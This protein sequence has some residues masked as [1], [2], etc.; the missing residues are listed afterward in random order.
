MSWLSLIPPLAV[1]IV[2]IW[3]KKIRLALFLGV[4]LA[5]T[6]ASDFSLIKGLGLALTRIFD[7]AQLASV[8]SL[9]SFFKASNLL[10]MLFVLALGILIEMIRSSRA[11]NAFVHFTESRI[12]DQKAAETSSLILSHI[13]C[14]DDYLSSLTVGSVVR[15]I[16]DRFRIS[17]IKLAFLTDSMAAPITMLTPVSSWAA[18]IIG[19]LNDNGVSNVLTEN[20][21]VLASPYSLYLKILPY[22][23]YSA[24]LIATVWIIVRFRISFGLIERHDHIA[25]TTGNLLG[26]KT[27]DFANH[28]EKSSGSREATVTDFF[29]PIGSL[30]AFTLTFLLYFGGFWLFGGDS[31]FFASMRQ[32]PISLV[33][34]LAGLSSILASSAYYVATHKF[35]I[36]ELLHVFKNGIKLMFPVTIILV[37]AWTMGGLLRQDLQTGQWIASL[38]ADA[39]PLQ[40]LPLILF[41]NA[42]LI[43]LSLGSSWATSAILFPIAIPMV[44]SMKH[45]DGAITLEQLPILL[46]VFGAILSGAVCGDHISLI[47]DTTIMATS[48][49]GCDLVD[50]VKSQA[51]YAAPVIFGSSVGYATAGYYIDDIASWPYLALAAGLSLASST[52]MLITMRALWKRDPGFDQ[53]TEEPA[54]VRDCPQTEIV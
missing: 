37:L 48:S 2:G 10:I 34:F 41:W 23:F 6:I 19:F 36:G 11:A 27:I 14:I 20:T 8:A 16:T 30:L 5:A 40:W 39:V 53:K 32:A 45:L 43:S 35:F 47:S 12:K 21:L 50:H 38:I 26:G 13:L 49:S 18:A 1:F 24:T 22:I 31:G 42:A 3:T 17:R 28:Q 51:A 7:N 54:A 52:A 15:P 33:L 46:P 4:F 9:S 25:K 29:L 44:M